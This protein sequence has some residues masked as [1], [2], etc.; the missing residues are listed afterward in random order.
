M[1]HELS[2]SFSR[3]SFLKGIAIGGAATALGLPVTAYGAAGQ[4]KQKRTPRTDNLEVYMPTWLTPDEYGKIQDFK[5]QNVSRFILAF[6]LPESDGS[7]ALPAINS[8]LRNLLA[9]NRSHTKVGL[10][11][12]GWGDSNAQHAA[13]LQ[14]WRAAIN[15]PKMFV[16]STNKAVE[17]LGIDELDID[18]EFPTADQAGRPLTEFTQQLREGLPTDV[19]IAMAVSSNLI[20][21]PTIAN[22]Q[23]GKNGLDVDELH[24]MTY[25]ENGGL[26]HQPAGYVA[27]GPW[28]I[29]CIDQWVARVGD[30]SKIRVGYPTYGYEYTGVTEVGETY[31]TSSEV[32]YPQAPTS[33]INNNYRNL[34]TAGKVGEDGWASFMSP[35]IIQAT[36]ERILETY[37]D[38]G[39][40]FLWSAEGLIQAHLNALAQ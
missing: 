23:F 37:P 21:N 29:G 24:V 11:V 33:A 14:G 25:D 36:Q 32:L 17:Q 39:G 20:S 40:A 15:N 35:S 3:R 7:I 16:K 13:N 10:A 26:G 8:D 31:K 22:Y 27:S 4:A 5:L 1:S 9:A 18:I 38:I 34:T 2:Q 30:P 28:T 19:R 12:G 6:A